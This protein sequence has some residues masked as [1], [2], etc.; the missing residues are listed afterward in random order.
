M[1]KESTTT[2]NLLDELKKVPKIWVKKRHGSAYSTG[3]PDIAGVYKGK[4]FFIEVKRFED[5]EL[6]KLQAYTLRDLAL[7]GSYCGLYAWDHKNKI[8]RVADQL[9]SSVWPDLVGKTRMILGDGFKTVN[10]DGHD[11]LKRINANKAY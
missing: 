11:I 2:K 4:A 6:S 5:G 7:A 3:E 8:F 9:H 1:T 10:M